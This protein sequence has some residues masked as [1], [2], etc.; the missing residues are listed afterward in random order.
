MP[1][2][3]TLTLLISM[4]ATAGCRFDASGSPPLVRDQGV[5]QRDRGR[6]LARELGPDT[7]ANPCAEKVEGE[8]IC[9]TEMLAGV[10]KGGVFQ[11]RRHCFTEAKCKNGHCE[12]AKAPDDCVAGGCT[13]EQVCTGFLVN[14]QIRTACVKQ[15]DKNGTGAAGASCSETTATSCATG[16]C[17]K[18]S[19]CFH[20]CSGGAE[21]PATI[22][23]CGFVD[24]LE[25]GGTYSG[26]SCR[27]LPFDGGPPLDGAKPDGGPKPDSAKPD[28]SA[29]DAPPP[30][31]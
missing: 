29:P 13:G 4:G 28:T 1:R 16:L 2:P 12:L 17:T 14:W 25:G 19:V 3:C 15:N 23:I 7:G 8:A 6:D 21:C 22:G 11:L 27:K 26:R 24:V 31:G 10:C 20:P 18:D 5:E 9:Q 30:G